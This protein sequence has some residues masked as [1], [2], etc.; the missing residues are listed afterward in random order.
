MWVTGVQTCALPICDERVH[1]V[2]CVKQD[3]AFVLQRLERLMQRVFLAELKHYL[4]HTASMD[5]RNK[6]NLQLSRF[7]R[8]LLATTAIDLPKSMEKIFLIDCV[9][10]R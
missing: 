4:H 10:P 7:S 1:G 2:D 9:S 8:F 5:A 6:S 3:L